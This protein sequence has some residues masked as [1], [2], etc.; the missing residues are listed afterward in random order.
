MRVN[1]KRV[2]QILLVA[3]LLGTLPMAGRGAA[4]SARVQTASPQTQ[5]LVRLLNTSDA[6]L[7][8][9]VRVPWQQLLAEP[10]TADGKAYMRVSLE[11][12]SHIAEEGA[13][14]LPFTAETIGVPFGAELTVEVTPGALHTRALDAPVLPAAT[15]VVEWGLPTGEDGTTSE[16]LVSR[17]TR[18]DAAIYDGA[19]A[20]PGVLAEVTSDGVVRQ[21]R[22]AG[23]AVYP[24]QY[25]PSAQTLSV[26]ESLTV[27]VRFTGG[28]AVA[29]SAEG[30]GRAVGRI[31]E[32]LL[33]ESLLNYADARDWRAEASTS[34]RPSL[35][36][37]AAVPWAPPVPGWR[38][39]VRDGGIYELS[40][41]ELLAAGVLTGNPDPRTLQMFHLGDEVAIHVV[42]EEDG[43]FDDTDYLLFYGEPV[44]SKYT[45]D[46]VYWLTRGQASGLRM[47]SRDATPVD[48]EIPAY[49]MA[50]R[51]MES[52]VYYRQIAPGS[53]ELE[54]W[55]W[56]YVYP[57]TPDVAASWT[58][59]F[60]LTTPYAADE[61]AILTLE[62][63]GSLSNLTYNPDHHV[64]ILVN[65]TQVAEQ[66]WDGVTWVTVQASVAQDLLHAGNNTVSV[67]CPNDTGLG[68][69]FVFIDRITL[70]S[71]D[72]YVAEGDLLCFS[73]PTSGTWRF[74]ASGFA[75]D[76]I[77]VYDVTDAG[78]PVRVEG[79][80]VSGAAPYTVQFQDVLGAPASYVALTSGAHRTVQGIE[81]DTASDLRSAANAA[82]YLIITHG[83]FATQAEQLRAFRESQ[84]Y[85]ALS[86]DV[87]DLYDE[88][89][90][91]LVDVAHIRAFLA[92]AY[93]QWAEAPSIVVLLGD[94]HYDPKNY[95]GYGRTNHIPPY[96]AYADPWSG[97]T[98]ADNRYVA[99]DGD[100]LLPDMM[101]GRLAVYEV[102]DA[103]AIVNKII[104]YEAAPVA[105]DW[106]RQVLLVADNE[107]TGGYYDDISDAL[108]GCCLPAPYTP[109]KVYYGV[110]HTT[111]E[112]ART[113]ILSAINA[114]RLLVNY[115]GHASSTLWA[116]EGLF[117]ATDVPGLTN[118]SKLPVLLPMSCMDGYYIYPHS[119]SAYFSLA[120]VVTRAAGK[121]AVASWSPT[122]LGLATGHDYLDRGFFRAL[123]SCGRGAV[124]LGQATTAGKLALWAS[125]AN[126]DLLDT[127]LLFGDPATT[128][129]IVRQF[130]QTLDPGW[131]LVSFDVN[132][133]SDGEPVTQVGDVLASL[134]GSYDVVQYYDASDVADPWK[135]YDPQ[136]LPGT[137]DLQALY[138]GQG[139]WVHMLTEDT[140]SLVGT[141]VESL[142][143]ALNAG[144]NMV[145]WPFRTPGSLPAALSS[146][147]GSYASVW[148]YVGTPPEHPWL[149]YGADAPDWVN[150]LASLESGRGYWIYA[151]EDCTLT[152]P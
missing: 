104:A 40:Y 141:P 19:A 10:V 39:K 9:E 85:S 79:L 120:E 16:P 72:A 112:A 73:Y 38:V 74:Q 84:G 45:L 139:F 143:M 122:G 114:G 138:P 142:E 61:P 32:G 68:Y 13:P 56:A 89:G 90:Y 36:G 21:Q 29:S 50:E 116:G 24:V 7:T 129:S 152:L 26:Y 23:I 102:A 96:L 60:V 77:G 135:L 80:G 86:V 88:F 65:G 75:T 82:E 49:H 8:L 118:E 1:L 11:G 59:S 33:S 43:R 123:F 64:Q 18:P 151:N 35:A 126:L 108:V 150:T 48:A 95:A 83:A 14:A 28:A 144:W 6:G 46:N 54:R 81:A 15:Q 41:D 42:G 132:P 44:T 99:V 100:D 113:A 37:T 103:S 149:R 94:G 91:G 127:Y 109:N 30:A 121:G 57:T 55:L 52:N 145:G 3:L 22:V 105:G 25:D 27:S 106:Q 117:R 147:E 70:T 124:T 92:Y 4:A 53:D 62:L 2:A 76:Q 130:E 20:W 5:A 136:G 87:Q 93:G 34:A 140:W 69:D 115:I 107:D 125:G 71:A 128:L 98:A 119:S 78:A 67:V 148:S 17:V 51:L 146:I 66:T 131:N 133:L 63:F 110:T 47:A 101:L 31:Y 111:V 97:E 137:N 58:H 134:A 12:W